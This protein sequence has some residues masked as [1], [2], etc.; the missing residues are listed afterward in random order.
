M[1]SVPETRLI[2]GIFEAIILGFLEQGI[3]LNDEQEAF[4]L[5]GI[6]AQEASIVELPRKPFVVPTGR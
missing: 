6:D 1:T 3:P 2:R 4:L 5:G